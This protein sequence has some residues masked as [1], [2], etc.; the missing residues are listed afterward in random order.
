M[1]STSDLKVYKT[2]SNL[3]GAIT[4]TQV[5]SANPNNL[6]VNVPNNE[7]VL[8]EDYY[9]CVYFKNTHGTESMDNFKLWLNSKT[10]PPDTELKWAFD[11]VATNTG[12]RW[13]PYFTGDGA[14][15]F[16]S[17]ASSASLQ[18]ATFSVS[19][20][21]KTSVS[22]GSRAYIVNK[23]GEGSETAGQNDNYSIAMNTD[24]T[25]RAGFEEGSGTDHY[26][27]S[28]LSYNDG[29]WHL[30][31][32]SYGGNTVRLYVDDMTTEVATHSFT[33]TPETTGTNPLVV[34]R[35]SRSS[36][37]FFNG[38]IDE[39]HVWEGVKSDA[40]R[41]A[42][43]QNIIS[44]TN[45]VYENKFGADTNTVTAQV[46]ADKYTA[47]TGVTWNTLGAE[48]STPNFG[49]LPAGEYF[50]IWLWLHVNAN[51]VSRIDD[52]ALF[53]FK[54]NIPQGGTGTGGGGCEEGTYHYEP[55]GIFRSGNFD[56][57]PDAPELSV[58]EMT[59]ACWFRTSK[60]YH[61][62]EAGYMIAKGEFEDVVDADNFNYMLLVSC[63]V[64]DDNRLEFN[65]E[66]LD[67]SEH[68]VF[69]DVAVNDGQWHLAVG[70]FD[71]T[72]TKV[73]L[74][75]VLQESAN[76]SGDTP[77]NNDYP[78]YIGQY[79]PGF[80][81]YEG[82]VDEVRIW[83]T[84]LTAQEVSDL[85]NNGDVPQ[86]GSLEYENT[87]GGSGGDCGGSGG[88]GG[89]PPPAN[90]DYKIAIAGDWGCESETDD[91]IDLIQDEDY[92]LVVGIGDN[93]YESA[94]CWTT[95]FTPLKSKMISAYGN[96]EYSES[97]GVNPYK[98]FFGDSKTYYTHQFQNIFFLIIDTNIDLDPGSD[99]HDFIVSELER[100]QN[101][102]TITW[103]IAVMHDAWFGADSDHGY[104]E[105]N[106]VDAFHELFEQHRVSFVCCGHNHNWQRSYQVGFNDSDPEDPT[107]VDNTSPYSRDVSGLIHVVSGTGGHDSGSSLYP[108]DS[109]PSFN[110]YQNRSHNGI[111]EIIASNNGQTL[112]C[113]FVDTD[114][115]KYDTFV[116]NA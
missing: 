29:L 82:D 99:Q 92:D 1:V 42:L 91:V 2:T 25:I 19:A 110:A 49:N 63:D 114:G 116:I 59:V 36:A 112:T 34:G 28:P 27:T 83:S 74:D 16:D 88:S 12:Y 76:H 73:Y 15:T 10:A 96:H 13:E 43:L 70:T 68:Y 69:S 4:G 3:G 26:A 97:G 30:V 9:A 33:G 104:N 65:W 102:N 106:Q 41:E 95:R 64:I 75:G 109:N 80:T 37:N 111:W 17:T 40:S 50:P 98:T 32:V 56:T 79:G 39:V 21:F 107:I 31:F 66:T 5:I 24:G 18:I 54:F 81:T 100:I 53:A 77:N 52:G 51:A 7:R 89:N 35:N 84:A 55:Y 87:F 78:L 6:F 62:D 105:F 103:K 93:A 22:H 47:P 58:T 61:D 45:L 60:D 8:G 94:S 86:T 38:F 113:S 101:D 48:P 72:N 67:G 23:G 46:I 108:L 85:Y 44:Q 71:G 115:S 57:I 11:P 20:W 14:T 90:T